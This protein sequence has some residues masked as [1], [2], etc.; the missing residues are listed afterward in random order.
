MK[1]PT[2]A[3]I[4]KALA[5][6]SASAA[7][8]IGAGLITGGAATWITGAIAT[9]SAFVLTYLVPANKAPDDDAL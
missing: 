4:R 3:E 7:V 5:A 9:V 2:L 8:A 6:A 1:L